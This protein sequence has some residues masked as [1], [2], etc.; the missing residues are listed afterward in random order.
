MKIKTP[1]DHEFWIKPTSLERAHIVTYAVA[2]MICG[3][4][5]NDPITE[6]ASQKPPYN[7][8]E[9]GPEQSPLAWAFR[10]LVAGEVRRLRAEGGWFLVKSDI[11]GAYEIRREPALHLLPL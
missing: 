9:K 8:R 11:A 10:T 3:V 1:P 7:I 2:K 5:H 6:E 4:S